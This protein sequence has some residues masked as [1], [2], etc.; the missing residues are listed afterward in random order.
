MITNQNPQQTKQLALACVAHMMENDAASKALGI[1][2]IE[3]DA[4]E[5][6]AIMAITAVMLNG[7]LSCHGGNIFSLADSA[8]AFACNSEN[9]AAVAAG[10]SIDYLMPAFKGD[11]LT[12][13][14]SQ[15][16]QGKRCG[17]YHVTVSNQDNQVVALFKGN[18]ARIKR[19]VLPE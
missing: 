19:S 11:V 18:S 8:F 14:A 6:T 16:H 2:V 5:V 9:F 7:H 10:C 12:A 4:G 1:K 15:L 3:V 13:K 17:I